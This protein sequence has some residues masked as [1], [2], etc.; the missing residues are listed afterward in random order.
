MKWRIE[1][2]TGQTEQH[3]IRFG[4]F[5][6]HPHIRADFEALQQAALKAGFELAIASSFRRFERQTVIWNNKFVGLRP[7]FDDVGNAIDINTLND[8]Q[9]I[10]AILRWSAMPGASRHHWGTDVDVYARNHLPANVSLQLEPWEYLSGHQA[11]FFDWLNRHITQYGFYFPYQKDKGGVGVEPWHISHRETTNGL[12][13]QLTPGALKSVLELSEIKG[14][15]TLLS[16]I[17]RIY[18]RY[19]CNVSEA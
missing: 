17:D 3:L 14:K 2:L 8:E 5:L 19:I 6:I 10:F 12:L 7:V 13:E 18:K 9:K 16:N 11:S 15:E 4:D 1:A